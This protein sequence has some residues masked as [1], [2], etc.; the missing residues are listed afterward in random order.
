MKRAA[1]LLRKDRL[2]DELAA[3]MESHLAMH[4]ADN[5]RAGMPLEEA[6]RVAMMKLGGMDAVKEAYRDRG[7]VP[8]VDHLARDLRFTFRQLRRNPGFA[9]TAIIVLALGMSATIAIFAFVDA[10]LIRPL[11]YTQATRLAAVTEKTA[12]IPHANLSY[13][14]YKDWKRSN[15]VFETLE[16]YTGDGFLLSTPSGTQPVPV[17]KVSA[18]FFRTLGVNPVLGRDFL[19]A[20]EA[21]GSHVVML[22]HATW[23][24]QFG[25]RTD[26]IGTQTRLSGEAFTIIGVLPSGFQFSPLG[27]RLFW[28]TV[29]PTGSCEKRRSCH[30]LY[31]VARLK[32]GET[33]ERAAAAM[34]LI[35]KQLEAQYPDSNRGQGAVVEPLTEIISGQVR[36]ILL[37]LM[38]C[39]GLLLL[40]AFVNLASLLLLRTEGRRREMSVRSALGAS[41]VR[42]VNQFVTEG[43]VVVVASGGAGLLLAGVAVRGMKGLIPSEMASYMPF[44]DE[45]GL[46][47]RV[48][49]CAGALAALAVFLFAV[50]P[51]VH[52]WLAKM[53]DGLAEGSRGSAGRAWRRIGARL[54]VVELATAMMLL[55]GAGLFG[56]SLYKLLNVDVG[57]RPDHLA[58][59]TVG[60]SDAAYGKPEQSSVLGREVVRQVEAIPGVQSAALTTVL[61]VSFN[62]NTTWIRIPG[63]PYDGTHM[64]VNERDVSAR[65]FE[66]IGGKLLRGRYFTESDDRSSKGVALINETL[67]KKYFPG[68]D[69]VGQQIGDTE[70]SP[71][72]LVTIVGV[73]AD[74][75]D[76]ALDDA[77]W[78]TIYHPFSQDPGNYFFVV[79]RTSQNPEAVLP[80][81]RRVIAKVYPDVGLSGEATM[82]GLINNSITAYL[83]RSAAWLVGGFALAAL[84]LGIV[85]LYGVVAYSV[86]QRTREIGVRM[87]LGAEERS[88]YRMVL[89]EAGWL[90]IVGI[91]VGAGG[92]VAA[93]TAARKLLFGVSSWDA[94]TLLAVALAMGLAAVAA[95][96]SPARRAARVNPVE[97]LRAE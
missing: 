5:V 73:V 6:R 49:L 76:G 86:S 88:V 80:E 83:H 57:L 74:V 40:I 95:S 62:G 10:A 78:P 39:A 77:I 65:F 7:S 60:G 45:L 92:A 61:P 75:R 9:A 47:G 51:A 71:K 58:T 44:L 79:A 11:P 31:G 52:V 18:G 53:R 50:T 33:M 72:S 82:E 87:A 13:Q 2:E 30:N 69:P 32:D 37:T 96:L 25:G 1:G 38:G 97:A 3:E 22:S 56:K 42:L 27:K 90:T 15:A 68:E 34:V 94:Q 29:D 84:V 20:E 48:L 89:R 14:D 91:V 16:V 93:A 81:L 35:A 66:T 67:A 26:V 23:Q 41:P 70:L 24:T 59:I 46:S 55:V 4:I 43:L 54:V 28:T 19:P 17:G 36:P 21:P 63:R 64:E 8:V 12:D 85:G